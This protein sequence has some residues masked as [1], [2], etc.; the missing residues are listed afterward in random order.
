MGKIIMVSDDT[1]EVFK[2]NLTVVDTTVNIP[3]AN[4][5]MVRSLVV[6]KYHFKEMGLEDR[7]RALTDIIKSLEKDL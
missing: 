7:V 3:N 5:L 2:D 6:A 1:I 4:H